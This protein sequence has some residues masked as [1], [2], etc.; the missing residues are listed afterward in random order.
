LA[1]AKEVLIYLDFSINKLALKTQAPGALLDSEDL[2]IE[3][4]LQEMEKRASL[5]GA[6]LD[7]QADARASNIILLLPV[8]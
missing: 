1:G 8:A 5:I 2:Q 3:K 6:V 7:V 4:S